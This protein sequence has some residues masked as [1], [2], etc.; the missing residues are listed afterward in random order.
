M[1]E[2]CSLPSNQRWISFAT[3]I[4]AFREFFLNAHS[5]TQITRQPEFLAAFSLAA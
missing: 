1:V 5:H 4:A 2:D 3:A